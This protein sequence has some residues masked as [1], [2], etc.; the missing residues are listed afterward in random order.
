MPAIRDSGEAVRG[1]ASRHV[2]NAGARG[3]VLGLAVGSDRVALIASISD[4]ELVHQ[5]GV[6]GEGVLHDVDVRY[7]MIGLRGVERRSQGR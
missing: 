2:E 6:D 1:L 3:R 7:G 5:V 4:G